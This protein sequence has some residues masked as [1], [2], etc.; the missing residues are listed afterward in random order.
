MLY[1][2]S[3]ILLNFKRKKCDTLFK[4]INNQELL[5]LDAWFQIRLASCVW[6][7][8]SHTT[9]QQVAQ[10]WE[11]LIW[12]SSSMPHWEGSAAWLPGF[13]LTIVGSLSET[14]NHVVLK[15]LWVFLWPIHP[16]ITTRI[17]VQLHCFVKQFGG[18]FI[19]TS[20][21]IIEI[22][23]VSKPLSNTDLS[24]NVIINSW[25]KQSVRVKSIYFILWINHNLFTHSTIGGY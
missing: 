19:I 9:S 15:Q 14:A 18:P 11:T 21:L 13:Y 1:F 17:K 20:F 10:V 3:N 6:S 4:L 7:R 25:N 16:V 2:V 24:D 5:N 23:L 22:T 12:P 8:V